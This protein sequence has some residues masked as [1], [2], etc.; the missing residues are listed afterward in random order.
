[1]K[2]LD[3][4][5]AKFLP[6]AAE[7]EE[8]PNTAQ[9]AA[10]VLVGTPG[11]LS[12]EQL[13]GEAPTVSWDLWALGVT[14]YESLT[15]VLPFPSAGTD[16]WRHAVLAGRPFPLREHLAEAPAAWEEFMA[17]ALAPDRTARPATAAEFLRDL[18]RALG[19]CAAGPEAPETRLASHG[20]KRPGT[21][22]HL[23][24]VRRRPRPADRRRPTCKSRTRTACPEARRWSNTP[25]RGGCRQ[26]RTRMS[27]ARVRGRRA[28]RRPPRCLS[29]VER[30]K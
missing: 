13:L 9:T 16:E 21:G 30:R 15:G 18:E 24:V 20:T 8:T 22:R 6:G 29:P 5:I 23:E 17:R 1:M 3:F 10:G 11:Y 14:A 26:S 25:R 27:P 12:P 2:V 7:L 19:V 4:G 28:S